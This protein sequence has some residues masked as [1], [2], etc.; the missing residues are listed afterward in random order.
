MTK[1]WII[2]FEKPED[3][4]TVGDVDGLIILLKEQDWRV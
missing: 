3:R 4:L 1:A 2:L